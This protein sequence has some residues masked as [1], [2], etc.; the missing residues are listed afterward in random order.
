MAFLSSKMLLRQLTDNADN[1]AIGAVGTATGGIGF[2]K[3]FVSTIS[4]RIFAH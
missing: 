3:N 2:Q 1:R 4:T